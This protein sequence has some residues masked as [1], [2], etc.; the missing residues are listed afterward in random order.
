MLPWLY[1]LKSEEVRATF[2]ELVHHLDTKGPE[3]LGCLVV[4]MTRNVADL[5]VVYVLGKEVGL[6]RMV[7][8]KMGVRCRWFPVWRTLRICF[9]RDY[10]SFSEPSMCSGKFAECRRKPNQV[11]M[12]G[13]SDSNKDTGIIASQWALQRGQKRLLKIGEI[14]VSRLFHG[15]GGTVG[16]AGPTHRFWKLCRMVLCRVVYGSQSRAK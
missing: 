14:T 16:R 6:T 13:Y 12:L 5:L 3:G 4:S 8:G 10:G 11:I 15:R 7:D 1:P 9:S 2:S